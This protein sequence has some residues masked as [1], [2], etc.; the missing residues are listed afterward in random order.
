MPIDFILYEISY[1]NAL[2]F[3]SSLPDYSDDGKEDKGGWDKS[4]DANDPNN[5]KQ[6]T[7]ADNEPYEYVWTQD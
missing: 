3:A 6:N 7:T 5:F 2:L 4:L 1:A